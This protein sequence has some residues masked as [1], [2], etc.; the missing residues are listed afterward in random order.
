MTDGSALLMAMMYGLKAA[1]RWS[2]HRGVNLLDSGAHFY[3]VYECAD[4]KW[5][6]IGSIEPQFYALLLEKAGID[7]PDFRAQMD[8]ARWPQL[9]EKLAAVIKAKTRD[10]WCELMEGSDVCFAPVLDMD[11]APAHAHNRQRETFVEIAGVMQPAPA[12]RFSRTAPDIP[13]A[14]DTVGRHTDEV[15]SRWG[16]GADEIADLKSKRVIADGLK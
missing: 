8:A 15:L 3:D 14:P 1:H 13:S 2:N 4:E 9:K 11:E 6:A 5:I 10:E 12:P 7:D 16:F